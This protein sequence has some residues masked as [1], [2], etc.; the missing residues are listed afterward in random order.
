MIVCFLLFV[1]DLGA[2]VDGYIAVIAHTLVVG[3]TK[4]S[5][6]VSLSEGGATRN[7]LMVLGIETLKIAFQ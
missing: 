5:A 7:L 2:Q 6:P 4:V 3:A 1:S